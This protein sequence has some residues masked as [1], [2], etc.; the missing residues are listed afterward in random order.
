MWEHPQLFK[1]H[2]RPALGF[3]QNAH[4]GKSSISVFQ[5]IFAS[6]NKI[7]I[8][9]GGLRTKHDSMMIWHFGDISLFPKILSF[10]ATR[11][12]TLICQFAQPSKNLKMLWTW[13][14][15]KFSFTFYV[16]INNFH[17]KKQSYFGW[18]LLYLFKKGSLT[19]LERLSI[20]NL[21]IREKIGKV[22]IKQDK[23]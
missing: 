3:M 15:A 12:A 19:K 14:S 4:Y 23:F 16:F 11:E 22:V 18:N 17:C 13:W 21:D 8:S 10:S 2:L 9:G 20:P 7:F 6:I 5:K 1:K